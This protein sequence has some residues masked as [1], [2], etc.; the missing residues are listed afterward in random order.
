VYNLVCGWLA[1]FL[2]ENLHDRVCDGGGEG[3]Q[4]FSLVETP[5]MSADKRGGG[6]GEGGGYSVNA[7]PMMG[8]M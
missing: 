1:G 4:G 2:K 5:N 7:S 8:R 6:G 3:R